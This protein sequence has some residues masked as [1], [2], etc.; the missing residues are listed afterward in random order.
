MPNA[1]PQSR[2]I[3]VFANILGM[4]AMAM[5]I[6]SSAKPGVRRRSENL[7]TITSR[8]YNSLRYSAGHNQRKQ[9]KA[10]R[11]NP[12]LLRSKKYS[13]KKH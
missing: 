3:G 12:S 10:I 6:N 1:A 5:S 8:K 13:G 7:K 11:S 9:R 4:I 2:R